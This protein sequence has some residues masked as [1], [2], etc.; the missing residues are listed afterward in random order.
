M[1][2]DLS[3]KEIWK[4]CDM[5]MRGC[6]WEEVKEAIPNKNIYQKFKR[7]QD[8]VNHISN[9]GAVCRNCGH[10]YNSI[11]HHK[12]HADK[13]EDEDMEVVNED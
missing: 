13:Y 8:I 10:T 7:L 11:T 5:R 12:R 9:H 6:T 2:L 3:H 4:V 1:P